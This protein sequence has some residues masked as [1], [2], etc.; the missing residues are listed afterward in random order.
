M[1]DISIEAPE[2]YRV[3]P[4]PGYPGPAALPQIQSRLLYS[5]Q[6]VTVAAIQAPPPTPLSQ[7]P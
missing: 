6:I 3:Q 2:A 5:F 1:P 4:A 7:S